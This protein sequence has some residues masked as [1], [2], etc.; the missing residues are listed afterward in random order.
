MKQLKSTIALFILLVWVILLFGCKII[1]IG[2]EVVSTGKEDKGRNI[3]CVIDFSSS[4]NDVA[5]QLFYKNVI[6]NNVIKNL[7]QND[8]IKVVPL[9]KASVTNSEVIF[10]E[11]LSKYEVEPDNAPP[12]QVDKIIEDN[13]NKLKNDISANFEKAYSNASE[14]RK[15]RNQG[16]DIFGILNTLKSHFKSE[17]D[18]Y[19]VFLSDMMNYSESLNMEPSNPNFTSAKINGL[20]KSV[21]KMHLQNSTIL[22]LTGDQPNLSSAHFELVRSFWTKYFEQNG[23]KL[24]DYSSATVTKLDEMIKPKK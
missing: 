4:Q 24:Y 8:Q 7:A 11:D 2:K 13:V 14:S 17:E 15:S 1:E 9:D 10:A 18:N 12:L 6:K 20:L 23:G 5:R 3:I 21:P 22:V 16:T 19:V